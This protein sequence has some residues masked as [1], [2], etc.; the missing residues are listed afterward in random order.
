[1]PAH[2]AHFCITMS[3]PSRNMSATSAT[4]RQLRGD[5]V[6]DT[7]NE[8]LQNV[9][10]H[11]ALQVGA[12]NVVDFVS[13]PLKPDHARRPFW[14]TPT[15]QIYLEG[16]CAR[17]WRQGAARRF[18]CVFLCRALHTYCRACGVPLQQRTSCTSRR[19]IF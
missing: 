11:A 8:R 13:L 17:G 12:H 10:S 15:G 2:V 4:M 9:S 6:I 16:A 18:L 14:V 5:T 3:T 7:L 1:M 19:M